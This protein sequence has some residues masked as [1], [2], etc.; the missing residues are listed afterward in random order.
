MKEVSR[1]PPTLGDLFLC[2]SSSSWCQTPRIRAHS[3][4]VW[5]WRWSKAPLFLTPFFF[6][7]L[8]LHPFFPGR[9]KG[10]QAPRPFQISIEPDGRTDPFPRL[11][12]SLSLSRVC[13]RIGVNIGRP[14][15]RGIE[16]GEERLSLCV[17]YIR[18]ECVLV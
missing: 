9:A 4:S 8:N 1:L 16:R 2:T 3:L 15:T 11:E 7:L 14:P 10:K 17:L 6:L 18:G 5:R 12:L 13:R